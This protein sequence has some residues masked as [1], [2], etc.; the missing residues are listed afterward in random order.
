MVIIY[1][2]GQKTLG[3]LILLT[4]KK[5]TLQWGEGEGRI[6]PTVL[7]RV[8]DSHPCVVYGLNVTTPQP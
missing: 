7:T 2:T 8:V 4:V 5:I 6:V 1:N 3:H